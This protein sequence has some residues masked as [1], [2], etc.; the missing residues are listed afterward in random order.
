MFPRVGMSSVLKSRVKTASEMPMRNIYIAYRL[1]DGFTASERI[2]NHFRERSGEFR[3]FTN[4][5]K[6]TSIHRSVQAS[7]DEVIAYCDVVFVLIG[8]EFLGMDSEGR[9]RLQSSHDLLR[10]EILAATRHRKPIV[11]VLIKE[12][13]MPPRSQVPPE[14][15]TIY[16]HHPII[17][18][19]EHLDEDIA[20]LIPRPVSAMEALMSVIR[21]LIS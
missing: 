5:G 12:A 4:A 2:Y 21:R 16:R 7:I 1:E 3:V 8:P 14:L 13:R 18:R 6:N 10:I 11:P 20:R 17:L 19:S 15:H 9:A